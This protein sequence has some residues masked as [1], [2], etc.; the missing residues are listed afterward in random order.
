MMRAYIDNFHEVLALNCD[1]RLRRGRLETSAQGRLLI[2]QVKAAAILN[3]I[4]FLTL[5]GGNDLRMS[6]LTPAG[7]Q[8]ILGEGPVSVAVSDEH[9]MLLHDKPLALGFAIR[10][11]D[12]TATIEELGPLIERG[13]V[14]VQPSRLIIYQEGTDESGSRRFNTLF[15]DDG[16]GAQQ[17][18]VL[19]EQNSG[20]VG[21]VTSDKAQVAETGVADVV[22]PYLI[23]TSTEDLVKIMDDEAHLLTEFRAAIREL[24]VDARAK[25]H[26]TQGILHDVVNPRIAKLQRRFDRI[27]QMRKLKTG[28]AAV[29][30]ATLALTSYLTGGLVAGAAMLAGG[31]GLLTITKAIVTSSDELHA[32]RDEPT[33]LLWKLKQGLGKP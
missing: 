23:G 15:V 14:I 12:A 25:G 2:D 26:N 32:L 6:W 29:A 21:I 1:P 33:Y 8:L 31:S 27:A 19:S 9:F 11:V 28:G 7:N 3:D 17:W 13:H 4:S 5:D 22:L 24:I 20:D 30:T 10:D 18:E 16:S